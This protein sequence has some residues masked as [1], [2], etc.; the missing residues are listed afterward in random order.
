MDIGVERVLGAG[1]VLDG[2]DRGVAGAVSQLVVQALDLA[3]G[4]GCSGH[5]LRFAAAADLR[6]G[7]DGMVT[8]GSELLVLADQRQLTFDCPL[9]RQ[10]GALMARNVRKGFQP[11]LERRHVIE[12]GS[13]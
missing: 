9:E 13:L 5:G 11:L 8:F 4:D 6:L 1:G 10:Q 12:D 7:L 2:G 3:D